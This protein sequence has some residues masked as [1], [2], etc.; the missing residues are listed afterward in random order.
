MA[1]GINESQSQKI[2][3]PYLA[4]LAWHILFKLT[5][6]SKRYKLFSNFPT[7]ARDKRSSRASQEHLLYV[8]ERSYVIGFQPFNLGSFIITSKQSRNILVSSN[9]H[10]GFKHWF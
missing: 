8:S 10:G 2:F 3:I 4:G 6:A 1:K 7:L 9:C 5:P